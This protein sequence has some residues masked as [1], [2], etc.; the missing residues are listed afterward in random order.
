MPLMYIL[1]ALLGV[2]VIND[3]VGFT[4]GERMTQELFQ[5]VEH[6][7]PSPFATLF[8]ILLVLQLLTENLQYQRVIKE[9]AVPGGPEAVSSHISVNPLRI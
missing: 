4:M 6:K 2:A 3:A 9:H 5:A 7:R 8:I 1:K